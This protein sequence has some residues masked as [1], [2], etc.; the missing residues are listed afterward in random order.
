M[1]RLY[2]DLGG[3]FGNINPL[4]CALIEIEPEKILL[5]TDYPQEM[6]TGQ[7]VKEFVEEI[8][9]LPLAQTQIEGILGEN[10]RKFLK[11]I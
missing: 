10:G 3:C 6:R 4:K 11:N 9:K 2:F 8:K 1:N 5:G 7:S